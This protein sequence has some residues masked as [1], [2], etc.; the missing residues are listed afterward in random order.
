MGD[1][2]SDEGTTVH[3]SKAEPIVVPVRQDYL[4]WEYGQMSAAIGSGKRLHQSLL[5]DGDRLI[6]RIVVDAPE[7]GRH[8]FYFDV[9]KNI[10]TLGNLGKAMERS[11]PYMKQSAGPGRNDP[12]PCGSGK[13]YKKCCMDV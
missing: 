5:H 1:I 2:H 4:S 13:K 6:D 11:A 12:C 7:Q 3:G 9:T 10:L 8:V